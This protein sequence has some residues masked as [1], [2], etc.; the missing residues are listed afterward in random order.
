MNNP[1]L[2]IVDVF[3][4][5][6]F[7]GNQ[8]AVLRGAGHFS[9]ELMQKIALEMN[10]SETTFIIDE[11]EKDGGYGVRIFTPREELPFAG[12]PTLGSV[13]IIQQEIIKST[14]DAVALNLK[15]GQIPVDIAYKNGK[16]DLLEMTQLAPV[17]TES[18]SIET[19]SAVLNLPEE[20]FNSNFP[21]QEVSTGLPTLIIPLKS[22]DAV[23]RA[24]VNREK[25]FELANRIESK[26][27]MVFAPETYHSQND[28]N[29]RVFVHYFGIPEDPATGS[30][31]GCLAGY[32]ARHRFWGE[33]VFSA[34]VEQ[35][36]EIDRPSILH[37]KGDDRAGKEVLVKV[38]GECVLTARGELIL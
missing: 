25:Y 28:I 27:F 8:L 18:Y 11:E 35:G 3:A 22:L 23:R 30:S 4:E 9:T 17:F 33:P 1:R 32:L 10:Y 12:H 14:V 15:A 16:T 38:G 26:N 20:D 5:N 13:F 2:Y 6:R 19:L 7:E 34:R 31:N 37:L 21:I 24:R 29:A 36:Y